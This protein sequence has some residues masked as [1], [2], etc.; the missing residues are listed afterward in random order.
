MEH[1][2]ECKKTLKELQIELLQFAQRPGQKFEACLKAIKFALK[3]DKLKGLL[4]RLERQ[5]Q[6]FELALETLAM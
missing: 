1:L 6:T 5:K 3:S 2:E 4:D